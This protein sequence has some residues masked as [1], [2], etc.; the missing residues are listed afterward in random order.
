MRGSDVQCTAG[1]G[2]LCTRRIRATPR[3][4]YTSLSLDLSFVVT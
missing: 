4:L 1:T 3:M 2:G